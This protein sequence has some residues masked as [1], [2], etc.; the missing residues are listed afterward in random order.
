MNWN[1]WASAI[2][3]RQQNEQTVRRVV[4]GE[5]KARPLATSDS[6]VKPLALNEMLGCL[7][8]TSERIE[9]SLVLIGDIG[10]TAG[11]T[12]IPKLSVTN[13]AASHSAKADESINKAIRVAGKYLNEPL[14]LSSLT[15]RVYELFQQDLRSQQERVKNYGRRWL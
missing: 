4:L 12:A 5:N 6:D 11:Y 2:G 13:A 15:D 1:Q 9:H 10:G 7:L 14:I 3:E 8:M